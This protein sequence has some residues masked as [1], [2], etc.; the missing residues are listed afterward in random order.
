MDNI[1]NCNGNAA[2]FDIILTKEHEVVDKDAMVPMP[3]KPKWYRGH[4]TPEHNL[5]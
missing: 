1:Y 4:T 3:D 5:T 2:M